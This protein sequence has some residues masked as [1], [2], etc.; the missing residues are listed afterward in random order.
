MKNLRWFIG[1]LVIILLALIIISSSLSLSTKLLLPLIFAGFLALFRVIKGP[2]AADR[3]VASDVLGILII[4]ICAI[5]AIFTKKYW[6]MDIAIAWALQS[7][8]GVLALAKYLEGR[9]FDD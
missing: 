1:L 5:F 7:F 8:I 2:T 4:G 3:A 9:N 6:Y